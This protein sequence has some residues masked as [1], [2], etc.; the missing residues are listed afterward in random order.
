MDWREELPDLGVTK[1]GYIRFLRDPG[2]RG[3]LRCQFGG[4]KGLE[5]V[6][7]ACISDVSFGPICPAQAG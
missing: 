7:G 4:P 1:I 6:I 5:P 2:R 3:P